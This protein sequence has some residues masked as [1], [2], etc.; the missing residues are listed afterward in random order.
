[1]KANGVRGQCGETGTSTAQDALRKSELRYRR[2]FETAQDGILILDGET[3]TII[4][5]NPFL[6]DL[7]GYPFEEMFGRH[8]WEIGELKDV[9]AS[10]AAFAVLQSTEYVR[11]ENLPLETRSGDRRQVEFG[12]NVYDVDG[13]KIIQCNIREISARVE[14]ELAAR[15]HC[16]G[17][18]FANDAKDNVLA[19]VLH[20]LRTPLVEIS[21]LLDLLDLG[22]DLAAAMSQPENSVE[23][24]KSAIAHIRHNIQFLFS[25]TDQLSDI[26]HL[27]RGTIHFDQRVIDAHQ[28]ISEVLRELESQQKLKS[29][30]IDV[31][32]HA[33]DHYLHA[34]S[35]KFRQIL[36]NLIGNAIKFTPVGGVIDIASYNTSAGRI[37]ILVHDN[38]IGLEAK[39][40]A[41]IFLPFEQAD[42]SIHPQYGGLGLGLSIAKSLVEAHEGKLTVQSQGKNRG[43]TFILEFKSTPWVGPAAPPMIKASP[44]TKDIQ[45]LDAAVAKA[46]NR[47]SAE[48]VTRKNDPVG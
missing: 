42:A 13:E 43:A 10:K 45:P 31:Q 35:T 15:N 26:T 12:S 46:L 21:A 38:G 19:V 5:A 23:F 29:I 18:E 7:L 14:T 22:H 6:L 34:D 8:L 36:F 48:Q 9:A 25:V 20:E 37:I 16:V 41:R 30:S 1:M 33:W 3:G 39:D 24:D 32:L 28:E 4:D 17:L 27:T 44:P 11:Y 47:G 40:I 2:L